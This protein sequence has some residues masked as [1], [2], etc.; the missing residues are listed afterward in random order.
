M[1]IRAVNRFTDNSLEGKKYYYKEDGIVKS[2]PRKI[3]GLK[4]SKSVDKTIYASRDKNFD[5]LKGLHKSQSKRYI[6]YIEKNLFKSE[7]ISFNN[8]LK[9]NKAISRLRKNAQMDIYVKFKPRDKP[10][11]RWIYYHFLGFSVLP[12]YVPAQLYAIDEKCYF[13]I[14]FA[15]S[16]MAQNYQK[17]TY[18]FSSIKNLF[19]P[20]VYGNVNSL[21][22]RSSTNSNCI[23]LEDLEEL[24][25]LKIQSSLPTSN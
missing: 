20:N 16:S 6:L 14:G 11:F 25:N 19:K 5:L 21:R 15:S 10:Y 22:Q 13:I 7:S 2:I 24:E 23:F 18:V 8:F 3:Y 4:H 17:P 9:L 12:S 1:Y